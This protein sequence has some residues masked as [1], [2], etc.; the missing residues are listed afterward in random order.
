MDEKTEPNLNSRNIGN[1][2]LRIKSDKNRMDQSAR[3]RGN[4]GFQSQL[5]GNLIIRVMVV[6]ME[7]KVLVMIMARRR[8][9]MKRMKIMMMVMI[10]NMMMMMSTV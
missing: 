3:L 1:R 4:Q 5:H 8:I 6:V 2:W 7:V 10:V 9:R